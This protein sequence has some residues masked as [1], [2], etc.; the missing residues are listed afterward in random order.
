V[1]G[2]CIVGG[3]VSLRI[4]EKS[5]RLIHKHEQIGSG[6]HELM[7]WRR[8]DSRLIS[9]SVVAACR[10]QVQKTF[11]LR[12][13]Q[14]VVTSKHVR[15]RRCR[16]GHRVNVSTGPARRCSSASWPQRAPETAQCRVGGQVLPWVARARE[17]TWTGCCWPKCGLRIS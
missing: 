5:V 8:L 2:C 1:P 7:R 16:D 14:L 3:P 15:A 9:R 11:A 4:D 6:N 10:V 17:L 12:M 13:R